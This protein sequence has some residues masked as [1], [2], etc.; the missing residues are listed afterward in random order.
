MPEHHCSLC[1]IEIDGLSVSRGGQTLLHDV[2]MHIHCGQLTRKHTHP[3]RV[4]FF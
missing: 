1:H 4:S 2:S 3:I